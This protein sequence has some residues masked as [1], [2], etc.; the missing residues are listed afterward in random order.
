MWILKAKKYPTS[1]GEAQ[2]QIW[3]QG[4]L[5]PGYICVGCFWLTHSSDGADFDVS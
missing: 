5:S 2:S 4:G 1:E 3:Q